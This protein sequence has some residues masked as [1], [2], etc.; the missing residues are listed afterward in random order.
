MGW[1]LAVERGEERDLLLQHIVFIAHTKCT[2]DHKA[3]EVVKNLVNRDPFTVD[4][5][6][7]NDGE[8]NLLDICEKAGL[9]HKNAAC[10]HQIAAIMQ[11]EFLSVKIISGGFGSSCFITRSWS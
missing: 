5:I 2:M 4:G 6:L 11:Q 8:D 3:I 9:Q 10:M 1:H 7:D